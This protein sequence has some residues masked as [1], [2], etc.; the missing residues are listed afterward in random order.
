MQEECD[1]AEE[2]IDLEAFYETNAAKFYNYFFAR[3]MHRENAEDLTS[4][5]FLKIAEAQGSYSPKKAQLN[6]WAWRIARNT[7]IDYY[8]TQKRELSLEELSL[9]CNALPAVS[10]E[11]QYRK[12]VD[13]ERRWLYTALRRLPER[14]RRLVCCKYCMGWSYHEISGYFHIN[15]STLATVLWRAKKKLQEWEEKDRI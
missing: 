4:Q 12:I 11:E 6:A 9:C 3:L 1:M 8:R 10:F 15:E 5:T 7:L 13:P 14:D 2:P